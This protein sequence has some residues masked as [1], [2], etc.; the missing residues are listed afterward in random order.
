MNALE[1]FKVEFPRE[2][3][4]FCSLQVEDVMREAFRFASFFGLA[5]MELPDQEV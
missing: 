1:R 3:E 2:A 5:V 4:L